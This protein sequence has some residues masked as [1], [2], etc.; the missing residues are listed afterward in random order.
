MNGRPK[1]LL[2]ALPCVNRLPGC[3][4]VTNQRDW[5]LRRDTDDVQPV[6]VWTRGVRRLPC[7]SGLSRDEPP[8]PAGADAQAPSRF[9]CRQRSKT[10]RNRL[11]AACPGAAICSDKPIVGQDVRD[12]VTVGVGSACS[13]ARERRRHDGDPLARAHGSFSYCVYFYIRCRILMHASLAL[14][15]LLGAARGIAWQVAANARLRGS[16]RLAHSR[17]RRR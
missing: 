3:D 9:H 15:L 13:G 4:R 2:M 1:K 17:C 8:R 5:P 11:S 7:V 10:R 14:T 6:G 12:L 16:G